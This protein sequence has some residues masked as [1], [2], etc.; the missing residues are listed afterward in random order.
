M[1]TL[2]HSLL[3]SAPLLVL[4]SPQAQAVVTYNGTDGVQAN[5][6]NSNSVQVCTGC[7][8]SALVGAVARS[9]APDGVNF[10]NYAEATAT[11]SDLDFSG[12]IDGNDAN[13]VRASF[14]VNAGTMPPNGALNTTEKSLIAQW[15]SDGGLENAAPAAT[16]SA[17][18]SVSKYQ[19][20]F[21]GSV[22]E[23]GADTTVTFAYGTSS[24]SLTSNKAATSPSG[25]GGGIS[26]GA[27]SATQTSLNC[28][29]TYYFRLEATNSVG[30]NNGSTL[31]FTTSACNVAPT[32]TS[33]AGTTATEDQQYSY[34]LT[35]TDPDDSNNGTDL[36]FSLTN[37]PTGMTVSTTGLITWTPTEGVTSSGA[38]TVTV[39]DG[40]EDGASSDSEIFTVSVTAVN[41][42]P[43]ITSTA[44]TTATEDQQYSYQLTVSDPDDSN[45]GTDLSFSL[46][47]E[48]SGMVVST[49]G[50]VTWTP[51]EGVS[52]SGAVTVTVADGGEDGATS[53]SEIFTVSVTA[54]N[55]S[56][57]ITSTAGTTATEDIAYSYQVTVSDPDDSNNGTDL[58]FSLTNQPTGMTV[59]STGLITWTATEGVSSSGQVTVT[60]ADGGEDGATSDS[61]QFT[62][63]VTAVNDSPSITSTASTTATEDQQYSYQITVS[64]PDDSNNGTDITFAL[65][66]EPSGMTV[67]STGLVTWTPANGVTS[68][69]QVT[70]TVADGGEDGATS[71]TENWTVTV[72]AVNDPPTITSTAGTTATEDIQYSYQVVVSDPDDSNNGTDIGFVLTNAPT[73]MA[74]SSTGLITWTPTEGVSTSGQVTLTVSDGGEDG[75]ASDTEQFTVSVTAV[76]DSPT[77]TS[78]AST[79]AI[80]A[81]LYSYQVTVSDPDDSNNGIDLSFA[82]SNEPAGM[83]VSATGLVTWTPTNGVLSSGL[84]TVTVSDGGEDGATSDTQDW[85][86][87]VD[88]VNDPPVITSTAGTT[89]TE[90]IEYSYQVVVSDPDDSNNGTDISF[91]LTNAPTGMAVSSTGLVTWTP[92]EG[93]S[94]SGQVTLTVADGGE[95]G[96]LPDTELF[97]ISVTSVN[98]SPTITSAASTSAV[99]DQAYSYQVVVSDPDDSNNGT[100]ISFALSNEPSGMAISSTGL[101]TWTPTNGV[102][103]SGQVTVTVTDGGE[104]GATSATQSWTISVDAVN[105]PPTITSTAGT[106]ATEDIEYSYQVTVD[107]PDDSNNGTDISFSLSN[108]PTGMVVSSTGLISWTPTEGVSTSGQV[109]LTVSDGG[110]NSAQPA[111][112]LFTISVTA[113]NDA[114]VFSSTAVTTATEDILYQYDANAS[115]EDGDSLT[116]SLVTAP[117]D[118]TIDAQTGVISWTPLEGVTSAN[119]AV[120]VSDGTEQVA[121]SFAITVTAVNDAP[122]ITSTEVTTATEDEAYQYQITATD[123]EDDSLTFTLTSG[124]DGMTITNTG[125][126]SWTPQNGVSSGSVALE[127]SD[128]SLTDSQS[129]T[130]SVTAVNDPVS[131]TPPAAQALVELSAWQL[132]LVVSDVDDS[133]DGTGITF[134]LLSAPTGLTVSSTG[135]LSW[136][137]GQ[138]TAGSYTLMVS[139]ADGLEDGA[140]AAQVSIALTVDLLDG[141]GDT[142]ADYVD[143]CPTTANTDQLDTD[144]DTLGNACDLDDDGDGLPD[145]IE[146]QFGLNPLDPADASLDLDGDSLTNLEEYTACALLQDEQCASLN[147]DSVAP[148]ISF[149]SPVTFDAE[150][151]LTTVS[152]TASATDGNDGVVD[153]TITHVDDEIMI[154]VD[155]TASLRPG[156]HQVTWQAIDQAGNRT[157]A[158]QEVR[159]RPALVFGGSSVTGEGA[160][161]SIPLSLD[162]DAIAYPVTVTLSASGSASGEDYALASSD[163]IIDD[164]DGSERNSATVELTILSDQLLES[165]ESIVLS[166]ASVSDGAYLGD[167]NEYEVLIVDRNVAPQLDVTLTQSDNISRRVYQDAGTVTLSAAASDANDDNLT[168]TWHLDA[169]AD[170]LSNDVLPSASDAALTSAS[171]LQETQSFDPQQLDANQTYE[172][173][174]VVSDGVLSTETSVSF[175][176]EAEQPTLLAIRDSDGDGI[177]DLTEG[178]TDSDGDGVADYQDAVNDVTRL[179]AT[180]LGSETT[181]FIEV[182]AG[183][184]MTI[185]AT[186]LANNQGGAFVRSDDLTDENGNVISDGDFSVVGG[187]Y[188]FEVKGLTEANRVARLVIPLTQSVPAIASY[189]K[190]ADGEWYEFVETSTDF[191]ESASRVNGYCPPPGNEQ[192]QSGL[193]RFADCLQLNISD[194]GPNDADGEVNGVIVD[195]S[196]V[197]TVSSEASGES[198][199]APKGQPSGS[200]GSFGFWAILGL[201]A[202]LIGKGWM[203]LSPARVHSY[204][205]IRCT[206]KNKFGKESGI[207]VYPS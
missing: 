21:N 89:A 64:D 128:G 116:F 50:L 52:S 70:V 107:D 168:L 69:G 19:A 124:P 78:A 146:E 165:D 55:D 191:I 189:R 123:P 33:T 28:G 196:G 57:A 207:D 34:Q 151:Y 85:T 27:V 143:N 162:G 72:T 91:S 129:F 88:A 103:S 106:S 155:G 205:H 26:A 42:S 136:L 5:I 4:M 167:V 32:I 206:D 94:T 80:E 68:S 60:V 18:S 46:T 185:G 30:S 15:V 47:N 178:L 102:T 7:H 83:T 92:T 112:E 87:T 197:A 71:A 160:T 137:P 59:S 97:T 152:L 9:S 140:T 188:D 10:D 142:V 157:S 63:L 171:E 58:S 95:S 145:A 77:I 84:V 161:L 117:T 3:R 62:V 54:V 74:V 173:S 37:E 198:L 122:T 139:V 56:P 31:N 13:H 138:N 132:Q 12:V 38:V 90:D 194:G 66:N 127:V 144:S 40:G 35:I 177:D 48:P 190:F 8:N 134:S 172:I 141:D 149:D 153:T 150:A 118:M 110:E 154:S 86:I 73:G 115:D 6:F 111:T 182:E 53:D 108:A 105:D 81:E 49:T 200:G 25:T 125:L 148:V 114:P 147:V 17:A 20:T 192:Y 187:L 164:T 16:T 51:T 186:A 67:S 202:L 156:V 175:L 121:Q 45:N 199:S 193:L 22:Y 163:I 99:E 109:T 126:I 174:V 24:M 75:A 183:L 23:N 29:T 100:D 130:V 43:S 61:E 11:V 166:V 98:D 120:A 96:A 169:I 181:D 195:P 184:Q 65:S 204:A 14:R 101:I 119:V 131:V 179:S 180:T 79:S 1:K 203:R 170:A 44:G 158:I 82:L 2:V 201:L 39:A 76:N 41:D 176:V 113:V 133:N 104:D 159:V 93:I 36:S 135:L